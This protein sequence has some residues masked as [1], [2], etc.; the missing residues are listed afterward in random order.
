M[1]NLKSLVFSGAKQLYKRDI[2]FFTNLVI[3]LNIRWRVV[4]IQCGSE[5]YILY[6]LKAIKHVML[7]FP[8]YS[9]CY[10]QF[11]STM[12]LAGYIVF[13]VSYPEIPV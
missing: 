8:H 12:Y 4:L 1:E 6:L 10:T 7:C 5:W 9:A 13:S 3:E 11:P 2:L